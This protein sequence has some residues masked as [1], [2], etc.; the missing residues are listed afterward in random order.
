MLQIS[1]CYKSINPRCRISCDKKCG[2]KI[3]LRVRH[4]EGKYADKSCIHILEIEVF[5]ELGK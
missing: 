2:D 5:G 4:D 3:E 1:K